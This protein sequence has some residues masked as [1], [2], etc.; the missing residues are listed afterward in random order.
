MHQK[1]WWFIW[2]SPLFYYDLL[3]QQFHRHHCQI[4]LSRSP[5]QRYW[6]LYKWF[7]VMVA[8]GSC[9]IAAF[10][11]SI[12]HHW[13]CQDIPLAQYLTIRKFHR[14]HR[15]V[16]HRVWWQNQFFIMKRFARPHWRCK[17][18]NVAPATTA[19][20]IMTLCL[21]VACSIQICMQY[22]SNVSSPCKTIFCLVS[23]RVIV[24]V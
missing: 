11:Y 23:M 17:G 14:C 12:L 18:A 1:G 6:L 7:I 20:I 22:I 13:C 19:T 4:A 10:V 16:L 3:L 5:E 2:C 24:R 9:W 15:A 21:G 8:R